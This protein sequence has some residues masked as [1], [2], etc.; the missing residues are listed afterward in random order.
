MTNAEH[1]SEAAALLAWDRIDQLDRLDRLLLQLLAEA[2][3]DTKA[4]LCEI[5]CRHFLYNSWQ[6]V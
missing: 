6:R 4:V 5:S 2:A 1:E 3:G